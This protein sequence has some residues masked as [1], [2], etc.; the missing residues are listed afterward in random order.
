[1]PPLSTK[2][3]AFQNVISKGDSHSQH[4]PPSLYPGQD[5]YYFS[6]FIRQSVQMDSGSDKH[7]NLTQRS[8]SVTRPEEMVL[9]ALRKTIKNMK[10]GNGLAQGKPPPEG[11]MESI[12]GN[13]NVCISKQL[14]TCPICTKFLTISFL[15]TKSKL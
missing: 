11:W 4:T 6:L 5:V 2:H 9:S 7:A 8:K 10:K 13:D 3:W 12:G 1:M 15:L 14:K